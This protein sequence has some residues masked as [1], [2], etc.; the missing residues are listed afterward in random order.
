MPSRRFLTLVVA[1]P[2]LIAAGG[3]VHAASVHREVL[4]SGLTL[5]IQEHHSTPAVEVR[6]AVRA[7]PLYEGQLL[8]SGASLL[9]Q[10]LLMTSAQADLPAD[11]LR[12]TIAALGNH[13][14][15]DVEVGYSTY[16][17]TTTSERSAEALA[18]VAGMLANYAYTSVDLQR[19]RQA[20]VG[21]ARQR[22]TVAEQ[23]AALLYR[24]HPARLPMAGMPV[25]MEQLT[26]DLMR[27]YQMRYTAANTA[28]VVVGNVNTAEIRGQIETAFQRYAL[29]GY[30]Q[31]PVPD[32]A[33]QFSPRLATGTHDGA[34][35]RVV[36]AW[37]TEPVQ[38]PD[39]PAVLVL[40]EALGH[41]RRGLLRRALAQ[42]PVADLE[43]DAALTVD[44]PGWLSVAFTA[45]PG[46]RAAIEQ[47][48]HTTLAAIAVDGVAVED[49]AAAR[50]A[51]LRALATRVGSV[52]GIADDLVRWEMATGDPAYGAAFADRIAAVASE[53]LQRAARRYVVADGGARTCT[54]VLRPPGEAAP[55][56]GDA[57]APTGNLPPR[58][59]DLPGGVRGLVRQ[60]DEAPLVH[61]RVALGGGG[62]ADPEGQSGAAALLSATMARACAGRDAAALESAIDAR[63]MTI[64]T[65]ADAHG[66]SLAIS[67]L[68][69]DVD[70]A[71]ELAVDLLARPALSQEDLD[72]ARAR[73]GRQIDRAAQQW[74]RRLLADLRRIVFAG[75]YAAREPLG[76]KDQIATIDRPSLAAHYRR[77]AVGGNAVIAVYGRCDGT[78]VAERLDLLLRSHGLP[79]GPAAV[80]P[81]AAAAPSAPPMTVTTHD[82]AFSALAMGWPGSGL[83]ERARDEGALVVLSAMLA[84]IGQPGGRINQALL[85]VDGRPRLSGARELYA[86]RGLWVLTGLI[87]ART[88]DAVQRIAREQIAGL[89]R[90]L[91]L[92]DGD[93]AGLSDAE[94]AAAKVMCVTALTLAQEDQAAAAARHANALIAAGD[95]TPEL[96]LVERVRAVAIPDLARVAQAWL[97]KDPVVVLHRPKNEAT[98]M[99]DSS[100]GE[101]QAAPEPTAR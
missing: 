94:L 84:G 67:C 58:E 46:E 93:P 64:T 6:V 38:H 8:G 78:R 66:L 14:A 18:L 75:H 62:A 51:V 48:I 59:L 16:A 49:L 34:E 36:L 53:D 101:P 33:P 45:A 13:F 100:S 1:L 28:V 27:K 2:L 52:R 83:G 41:E 74:D 97:D 63:G 39:M 60:V 89:A 92:P 15:A 68:P 72:E 71:L 24:T 25:V 54:L 87:D 57:A 76:R 26:V 50:G 86:D 82:A 4:P 40:A 65:G 32:E 96:D 47:T 98:T 5:V 61:V 37:R 35:P 91:A 77:L 95:F 23:L 30:Y 22:P 79:P 11:E 43:V 70:L 88:T 10:R 31:A 12:R 7:G 90:Q 42:A 20:L 29:G 80:P 56:A 81:P 85:A 19:E 17:V 3:R 73:V 21:Q 9:L 55:V 44:Q 69:A 99:I